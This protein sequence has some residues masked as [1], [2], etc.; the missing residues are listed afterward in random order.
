[1]LPAAMA[2]G[3]G[4]DVQ[5]GLATVIAGGLIP[6]TFLTLFIIPTLYFVLER[7]AARRVA[8]PRQAADTAQVMAAG[9]NI[10]TRL[11]TFH[12]RL[13]LGV[14][15]ISKHPV[16]AGSAKARR[17]L[18][19]RRAPDFFILG[20]WRTGADRGKRPFA[21]PEQVLAYLSRYTHRV[22]ISNSRP[23]RPLSPS[24]E[25]NILFFVCFGPSIRK[26]RTQAGGIEGLT[27]VQLEHLHCLAG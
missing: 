8:A 14:A 21:G 10:G 17:T 3:V 20:H 5:R 22:A 11:L 7:W 19:S 18:R 4:S 13:G 2:T 24:G 25:G 9:S 1:M 6:A 23:T 16:R 12:F 26:R 27:D 15:P